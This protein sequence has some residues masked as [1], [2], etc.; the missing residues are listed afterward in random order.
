MKPIN[1]YKVVDNNNVTYNLD[2]SGSV[3]NNTY[4]DLIQTKNGSVKSFTYNGVN[5]TSGIAGISYQANNGG[6]EYLGFA[7]EGVTNADQR[8][9]LL[10]YIFSKYS[11]LLAVEDNLIK[12]NIRLYPNPTSGKINISNPNNLELE[13]IEIYNIYG[14]KLFDD[15]QNNKIDIQNFA[16]GIYLVKIEGLNGKQGIYKIIKE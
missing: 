6:V 14:Q 1:N 13:S 7:L 11:N 12:Q 9:D 2:Q 15:I 3:L 8:K 10:N 5:S 4:P 16:R